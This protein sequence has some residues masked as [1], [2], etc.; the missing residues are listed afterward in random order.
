VA[1][2]PIVPDGTTV[3]T[4]VVSGAAT[5]HAATSDNS[6]TTTLQDATGGSR[7]QLTLSTFTIPAGSYVKDLSVIVRAS[8]G[9]VGPTIRSFDTW[10]QV[11]TGFG[12]GVLQLHG[13]GLYAYGTTPTD[14]ASI[15]FG[16]FFDSVMT[17]NQVDN[18]QVIVQAGVAA[19][20]FHL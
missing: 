12:S 17:Q 15:G 8:A 19:N 18:M 10:L 13:S 14:Y 7:V 16:G 11:P 5:A 3:N 4:F 20:P 9:I 6:D 2:N 1:I